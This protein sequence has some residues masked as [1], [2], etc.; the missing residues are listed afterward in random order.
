MLEKIKTAVSE[1][2]KVS[3]CKNCSPRYI[4]KYTLFRDTNLPNTDPVTSDEQDEVV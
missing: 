2:L 1:G 4:R 3:L